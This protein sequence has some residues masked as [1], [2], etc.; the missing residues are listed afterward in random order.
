MRRRAS[1]RHRR[2]RRRR[3]P[4]RRRHRIAVDDVGWDLRDRSL[5]GDGA[6]GARSSRRMAA[7]ARRGLA[8]VCGGRRCFEFVLSTQ[9]RNNDGFGMQV[10]WATADAAADA[11]A[12]GQIDLLKA[13]SWQGGAWGFAPST[14]M[15][16]A[17]RRRRDAGCAAR[18]ADAW[19]ARGRGAWSV[20]CLLTRDARAVDGGLRQ[21]RALHSRRRRPP[22]GG[23][24]VGVPQAAGRRRHAAR[25]PR[26]CRPDRPPRRTRRV[27][28]L[29][30]RCAE[31]GPAL[32][33]AHHP[34]RGGDVEK[35]QR[36]QAAYDTLATTNSRGAWDLPSTRPSTR[37][38]AAEEQARRT[39]IAEVRARCALASSLASMPPV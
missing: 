39:A 34:D 32:A 13:S 19:L 3:H 4:R 2:S 29:F 23:A 7:A 22:A 21:R 25:A 38:K 24:A 10:G 20:G 16:R 33:L 28:R 8:L 18:A 5:S 14:G 9:Q 30:S 15:V 26:R 35:Y 1:P 27:R 36:L 17:H 6:K 37:R 11:A 31:E 12:G